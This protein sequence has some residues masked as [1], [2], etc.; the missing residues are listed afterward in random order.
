MSIKIKNNKKKWLYNVCRAED[1]TLA[2]VLYQL[3]KIFATTAPFK[4]IKCFG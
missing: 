4:L 1:T 3:S 2:P